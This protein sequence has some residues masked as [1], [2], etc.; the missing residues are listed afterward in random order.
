MPD[1]IYSDDLRAASLD[2]LMSDVNMLA[3]ESIEEAERLAQRAR[4]RQRAIER[5][6]IEIQRSVGPISRH[7]G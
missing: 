1:H 7:S 3:A 5:R 6:M 4:D 2:D